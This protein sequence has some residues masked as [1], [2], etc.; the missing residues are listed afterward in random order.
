MKFVELKKSLSSPK[1]VYVIYG[2]DQYLIDH[3]IFLM[4][5]AIVSAYPEMNMQKYD[6]EEQTNIEL[7]DIISTLPFCAERRLVVLRGATLDQQMI[8]IIERNQNEYTTLAIVSPILKA[9]HNFEV[10]DCDKL[11]SEMLRKWVI[12]NVQDSGCSIT[13]NAIDTLTQICDGKLELINFELKKLCDYC[14]KD[15]PISE[16]IVNSMVAKTEN[17]FSYNLTSAY[18]KGDLQ[19]ISR[20]ID[21]MS[22]SNNVQNIFLSLGSYF[23]RMYYCSCSSM[24][25][26]ELAKLLDVKPYAIKKCRDIIYRQKNKDKYERDY[27]RY[28]DLDSKIKQGKVSAIN[29]IFSLLLDTNKK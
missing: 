18:E 29:A 26:N 9:K 11:D 12:K 20:I 25:D 23:R 13:T 15:C 19:L 16:S 2:N 14:G 24:A 5:Q 17:Y 1:P 8:D 21:N 10:V 7:A 27:K 4:I 28:I 22:K 6:L 3:S